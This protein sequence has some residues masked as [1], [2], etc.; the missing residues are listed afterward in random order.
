MSEPGTH[1][2]SGQDT[3]DPAFVMRLRQRIS[4]GVLSVTSGSGP[5]LDYTHPPGDPG[6]F[7]PDA[8]C[9]QVHADFTSMMIGGISALMLQTLHPLAL[10][11]VWDHSTFRTDMRGRLRRTATFIAGTTYGARADAHALIERVKRIHLSVT[12]VAPDGRPYRASDPALLTWVHVAEVSSFL[13]AHLRYVNPLLST[14]EQDRYYTE[15]ALIAKMLGATDVPETRAQVAEYLSSMR[16]ELEAGPRTHE[17]VRILRDAAPP[18]RPLMKPA[19]RLMLNAGVDLLPDWAQEMLGLTPLARMRAGLAR[20]GVRLVGPFIRWAHVNA[21]SK[22]A[23]QRA[24]AAP[25]V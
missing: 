2:G 17:V 3:S 25:D 15:V 16:P 13:A 7:G 5:S 8:V 24:A 1:H 11:G 20:P 10:A 22:R 21:V 23:R 6:L 19:V 12:G 4:Q 18:D 9:W 14:A